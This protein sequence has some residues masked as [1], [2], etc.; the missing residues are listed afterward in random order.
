MWLINCEKH[1]YKSI[2]RFLFYVKN[3]PKEQIINSCNNSS[4]KFIIFQFDDDTLEFISFI[5]KITKDI[6]KD[7]EIDKFIIIGE[8]SLT[9]K[10]L[11]YFLNDNREIE[12]VNYTEVIK[13]LLKVNKNENQ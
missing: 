12:V 11:K 7:I 8:K 1:L 13:E 3:I 10:K 9:E 6:N 2:T 4:V 5:N